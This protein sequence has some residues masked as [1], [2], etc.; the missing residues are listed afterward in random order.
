LRNT[1]KTFVLL[2][3]LTALFGWAGYALGGQSG[4]VTALLVAIAMNALAYWN[5]DKAV[6]AMYGAKPVESGGLVDMVHELARHAG[7]PPPR[8]YIIET[9]QPNAFATGRNPEHAAI[10][11]TR[12]I[13]D[14][15]DRRELR[16]VISH[17]LTHVKNRD[18]LTMTVT[19][20]LAGAL[21][22]LANFAMFFGFGGSRDRNAGLVTTLALIILAPLAAMLVQ[23][24]ISRTREYA[25][26]KGGAEISGDPAALADALRKLEV[27]ARRI[28][29]P[30][31]QSNPGTAHLFIVNPLSGR[32]M[33]NLFST[34]PATEN[35]IA[36]LLKIK[37]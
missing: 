10:A 29:N 7:L 34:H 35:R 36:A 24:A 32:A 17:E 19:A 14:I 30:L 13:L 37:K 20:T 18:T 25:A 22:M 27:M 16:A 3:G 9:N 6:L 11:I 8:V 26:D 28:P 33:D 5:A 15:L 21:S 31:A 12:G 1:L 23:M 2:A 4:M